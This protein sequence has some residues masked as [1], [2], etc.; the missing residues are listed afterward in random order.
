[1]ETESTG[2]N[3]SDIK[4]IDLQAST[5]PTGPTTPSR[6]RITL[7]VLA[8]VLF[9][10]VSTVKSTLFFWFIRT[11]VRCPTV[12]GNNT[13][14]YNSTSPLYSGSPMC[15]DVHIV[16][17]GAQILVSISSTFSTLLAI[18][19]VPILGALSDRCGRRPILMLGASSTLVLVVFMGFACAASANQTYAP[20]TSPVGIDPLTSLF[21]VLGRGL[22]GALGVFGAV[23]TSMIVDVSIAQNIETINPLATRRVQRAPSTHEEDLDN[24]DKMG[25]HIGLYQ[26]VKAFGTGCGAAAGVVFLSMNLEYYGVVWSTML[27]PCVLCV[28]LAGC[29][30]ETLPRKTARITSAI[31]RR[32]SVTLPVPRDGVM[33]VKDDDDD[34]DGDMT[35]ELSSNGARTSSRFSSMSHC[36]KRKCKAVICSPFGLCI[37]SRT[38]A[39]I[40]LYVFLFTLGGS[41]LVIVQSFL[42]TTYAWNSIQ[43][44]LFGMF[45]GCIALISVVG[46]GW[47]I[48]KFGSSLRAL[49]VAS[50]LTTCGLGCMVLAKVSWVSHLSFQH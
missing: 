15:H 50:M 48:P 6:L 46:A 26:G 29:A 39:I 22:E 18:I 13:I 14:V 42:T 31:V 32:Q 38:I 23:I 8:A 30:P 37:N 1:M 4:S 12:G 24:E 17:D 11:L 34:D 28:V 35:E 10:G 33:E 44:V 36:T 5:P 45:G 41:S 16:A 9:A 20:T 25:K 49:K 2:T 19:G 3:S 47:L 27:I 40:S 43:V 21:V 7:V